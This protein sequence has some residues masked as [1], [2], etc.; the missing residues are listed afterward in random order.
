MDVVTA[1][2]TGI[3]S[4]ATACGI[5]WKTNQARARDCEEERR[6]CLERL[7]VESA[8]YQRELKHLHRENKNILKALWHQD[9]RTNGGSA[10]DDPNETISFLLGDEADLGSSGD[11]DALRDC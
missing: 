9:P 3:T 4:V 7:G 6:Q 1:L 11:I 5:Q 10:P 8:K 2:I